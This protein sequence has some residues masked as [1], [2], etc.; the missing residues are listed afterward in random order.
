VTGSDWS[1]F[2]VIGLTAWTVIRDRAGSPSAMLAGIN[3][4]NAVSFYVIIRFSLTREESRSW[5]YLDLDRYVPDLP[6][7]V[8]LFLV[9]AVAALVTS[10]VGRLLARGAQAD[11]VP[12][13]E[14]SRDILQSGFD[15]IVSPA[16][17]AAV[18]AILIV[19]VLLLSLHAAGGGLEVALRP[20][21]YQQ[22]KGSLGFDSP[23]PGLLLV[24]GNLD[25]IGFIV[26]PMIVL[27]LRYRRYGFVIP[28]ALIF[29]YVNV[30]ELALSSRSPALSL[31]LVAIVAQLTSPRRVSRSWW[32]V[33]PL[34]VILYNVALVG[35]HTDRVGLP[36]MLGHLTEATA[37]DTSLIWSVLQGSFGGGF[38]FLEPVVRDE[39]GYSDRYQMLSL[40]PLLSVIDNF[41]AVLPEQRRITPSAPYNVFAELWFFDRPYQIAFI[42]LA[43]LGL[44]YTNYTWFKHK[45]FLCAIFLGPLLM[46]FLKMYAYPIRN[47]MRYFYA[48]V[49]LAA[50]VNMLYRRFAQRSSQGTGQAPR[51]RLFA[52]GRMA[53]NWAGRR[54]TEE[55][56]MATAGLRAFT[57]TGGP[58]G[59]GRQHARF[60]TTRSGEHEEDPL[61]GA[62][63]AE[64]QDQKPFGK[65]LGRPVREATAARRKGGFDTRSR[66]PFKSRFAPSP[67]G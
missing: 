62:Q 58:G 3:A 59:P 65:F 11:R 47:N 35:R 1:I 60:D 67:D 10:E 48:S 45:S 63:P 18:S 5:R 61:F 15:M 55:R 64:A 46:V 34:V 54:G 56:A 8:D 20:A 44:V 21:V 2:L 30:I 36:A 23:P 16:G 28:E 57:K 39:G 37:V 50:V 12:A 66:S 41:D 7:A 22:Y 38:H 19:L 24:H 29:L 52:D 33:L 40:S 32:V 4:I 9:I 26:G 49:I 51:K 53:G 14:E 13:R 31:L 17:N 42:A 43:M 27:H 6:V 25:I